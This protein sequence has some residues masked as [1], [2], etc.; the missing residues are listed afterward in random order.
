MPNLGQSPADGDVSLFG[1]FVAAGEGFGL[2]STPIDPIKAAAEPEPLEIG[3][4][5]A[6]MRDVYAL[7]ASSL[8][9]IFPG[10]GPTHWR[11]PGKGGIVFNAEKRFAFYLSEPFHAKWLELGAFHFGAPT[12]IE[13]PLNISRAHYVAFGWDRII[14]SDP[15]G[16]TYLLS[17][18]FLLAWQALGEDS[19]FLG[20]PTSDR[21]D[22]PQGGRA[23]TFFGG[24]MIDW[25]DLG[26]VS[27]RTISVYFK[28]FICYG[29]TSD[30]LSNSDEPYFLFVSASGTDIRASATRIHEDVDAGDVRAEDILLWRGPP[31]GVEFALLLMEHD[32][33]N[34]ESYRHWLQDWTTAAYAGTAAGL[35]TL[36]GPATALAFAASLGSAIPEITSAMGSALGLDDDLV[37]E[38]R[39]VLT[40]HD[41][42]RIGRDVQPWSERGII[43]N[44]LSPLMS[45]DGASYRACFSVVIDEV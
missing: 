28:G 23:Q 45:G 10:L 26:I 30:G 25:D 13:R 41:L 6:V 21:T 34:P 44:L 17:G 9:P 35:A 1:M 3:Y 8:G 27:L 29:E 22:Y 43:C 14:I 11:F 16:G 12:S 7:Q 2:M 18:R 38:A 4:I 19:S 20:L 24:I 37:A 40:P 33:G 15:Y 31:D 5:E 42:V 39:M 32:H 36:S